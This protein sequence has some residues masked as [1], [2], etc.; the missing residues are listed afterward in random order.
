MSEQKKFLSSSINR[1]INSHFSLIFKSPS[2]RLIEFLMTHRR[3]KV[4]NTIQARL[5]NLANNRL[6]HTQANEKKEFLKAIINTSKDV[7]KLPVPTQQAHE[8]EPDYKIRL[9]AYY[10]SYAEQGHVEK[11]VA[12]DIALMLQYKK[13][14]SQVFNEHGYKSPQYSLFNKSRKDE[15]G[16]TRV[17]IAD[18]SE[19]LDE[20]VEIAIS[21]QSKSQFVYPFKYN[22]GLQLERLDDKDQQKLTV[23]KWSDRLYRATVGIA[24]GIG[25]GEGFFPAKFYFLMIAAALTGAGLSGLLPIAAGIAGIAFL[26]AFS[27]NAVLF[28]GDLFS[29]SKGLIPF[30]KKNRFVR[31]EKHRPYKNAKVRIALHI[32]AFS[33]ALFSA[34]TIAGL[35]FASSLFPIPLA[36]VVSGLTFLGF[37]GVLTYAMINVLVPE[38]MAI[39]NPEN[40][41]KDKE[42]PSRFFKFLKG[43]FVEPFRTLKQNKFNLLKKEAAASALKLVINSAAVFAMIVFG[44]SVVPASFALWSSFLATLPAI[45]GAIG[46]TGIN[47]VVGIAEI[48]L[49][50]F[51]IMNIA[52]F[53]DTVREAIINIPSH[54][55]NAVSHIKDIF[56]EAK[57]SENDHKLRHTKTFWSNL[58]G[59]VLV[60]FAFVNAGGFFVAY[61][62][63]AVSHVAVA[64][65]LSFGG[66]LPFL[67][68]LLLVAA[69]FI[70]P[71]SYT[72]S[73]VGGNAGAAMSVTKQS[74][75]FHEFDSQLVEEVSTK[76]S[77]S[78]K[79]VATQLVDTGIK[80][81][82]V[83][84]PSLRAHKLQSVASTCIRDFNYN[85]SSRA[86]RSNNIGRKGTASYRQFNFKR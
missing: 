65:V 48:A 49:G 77:K 67:L 53:I 51:F 36:M 18:S 7:F 34:A 42:H 68:P 79:G 74:E 50:S 24:V 81:D 72:M 61:L 60:A 21:Q 82:G 23:R 86:N 80:P 14:V 46:V 38:V 30:F 8:S 43:L 6:A 52:R 29:T 11:G 41:R 66:G 40:Y 1:A 75:G 73:S 78:K 17:N 10:N 12:S 19:V 85:S 39:F 54:V 57:I 45:T 62:N 15:N 84:K 28:Q 3:N 83:L 9:R 59:K 70:A 31:D 20:L 13:L 32:L 35:S 37:V 56:K 47:I 22:P 5:N 64:S 4:A 69:R 16:Y 58:L 76:K 26:A 27:V 44:V 63:T 25:S 2:E 55:Q 33:L 71:I